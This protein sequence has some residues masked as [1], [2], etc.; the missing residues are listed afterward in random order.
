VPRKQQQAAATKTSEVVRND[1]TVF[2][3]V[4]VAP[5]PISRPRISKWGTYYTGPTRAFKAALAHSI[6]HCDEP[7]DGQLVAHVHLIC[8]PMK[9]PKWDAPMGDLDNLAKGPLDALQDANYFHD[10]RQIMSL[11]V[12]KRFATGVDDPPRVLV[13]LLPKDHVVEIQN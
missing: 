6:P 13:Y 4:P 2:I 8:T 11:V 9:A 7:L 3:T 12:T 1:G 5:V 10:D